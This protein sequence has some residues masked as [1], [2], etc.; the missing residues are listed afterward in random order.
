[1]SG[2]KLVVQ[3]NAIFYCKECEQDRFTYWFANV[4]DGS[5]VMTPLCKHCAKKKQMAEPGGTMLDADLKTCYVHF[6]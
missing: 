4:V 3:T 5:I 2:F 6:A 1:M